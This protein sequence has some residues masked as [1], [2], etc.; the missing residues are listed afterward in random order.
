MHLSDQCN[1]VGT[2]EHPMEIQMKLQST[3]LAEECIQ[4][5]TVFFSE[6][7]KW[8]LLT[9]RQLTGCKMFALVRKDHRLSNPFTWLQKINLTFLII[10]L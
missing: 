8:P 4:L 9:F 5:S 2:Y 6:R 7:R 10:T 1:M 3:L